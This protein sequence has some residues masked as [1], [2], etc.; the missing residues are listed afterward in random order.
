MT[1]GD[2]PIRLGLIG[3]GKHGRR[4]AA[5]ICNDFRDSLRLVA[6]TRRDGAQA[7]EAA[8][9]F[10]CRA[11]TDYRALIDEA[12][13][14]ALVVVVPPVA[15]LEIV[16]AAAR[17]GRPV[18]LEKPATVGLGTGRKLLDALAIHPVPV[19]VAQTLRYNAVVRALLA[20]CTEI[21]PIH[22]L[23]LTQ[24]FEASRLDWIDDPSRSGGGMLLQTGVHSFDLLRLLTG[25]EAD[26]VTCHMGCV[27]TRRTED[28]FAATVSLGGGA[29]LAVVSGSRAAGG[30]TGYIEVAGER[31]TL[32]GDHVGHRLHKVAGTTATPVSLGDPVPTVREVLRDF[33]RALRDGAP[34]PIPI[35]EGL[36]AVAIADACYAAA[37]S[38]STVG[39]EEVA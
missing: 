10:G 38:G 3:A 9:E 2:R 37:R 16:S 11:Y 34:M 5:H 19:M 7:A 13:V 18:L 36:R 17:A 26:G 29:A 23:A 25:M 8:R 24:R 35:Q 6:L 30:R 12:D 21:G 4:Y 31:G 22:S 1:L 32:V 15:H 39:V 27:H 28:N 14:D 20:Q 33:T